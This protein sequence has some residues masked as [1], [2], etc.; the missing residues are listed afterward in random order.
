MEPWC[1]W[2]DIC[3]HFILFKFF[4]LFCIFELDY[5]TLCCG[6]WCPCHTLQLKCHLQYWLQL[7][8]LW[9][10]YLFPLKHITCGSGSNTSLIY[11]YLQN[12]HE[13]V[14]RHNFSLSFKLWSPKLVPWALGIL[15]A[16][17]WVGCSN[18]WL[19]L[20]VSR[21]SLTFP[22]G[23]STK[24]KLVHHSD[25]LPTPNGTV[26]CYFV[27]ALIHLWMVVVMCK[28]SILR[29][30]SMAYFSLFLLM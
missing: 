18:I 17:V 3:L 22:L 4:F 11:L 15:H 20:A 24:T 5:T 8:A 23:L 27:V 25:S 21:Y 28:Q 30:L 29:V 6:L 14:V 19:S 1:I 10:I 2:N 9:I 16:E 13:K 7:R 26:T 12:W